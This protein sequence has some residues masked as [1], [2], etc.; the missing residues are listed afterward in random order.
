MLANQSSSVLQ[1]SSH[2]NEQVRITV[3]YNYLEFFSSLNE[4]GE[5]S[6]EPESFWDNGRGHYFFGNMW[7]GNGLQK[8]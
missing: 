6:R 5:K 3:A 7:K 2:Q 8:Q 4:G 1:Q